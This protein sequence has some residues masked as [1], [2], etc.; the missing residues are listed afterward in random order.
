MILSS[1]RPTTMSSSILASS[2]TQPT[3][4]STKSTPT[5]H[6]RNKTAENWDDD[7]DFIPR[8]AKGSSAGL[9]TSTGPDENA[10][11]QATRIPGRSS[12]T[13]SIISSWDDSPP[14]SAPMIPTRSASKASSA[15]LHL[16]LPRH[17]PSHISALPSPSNSSSSNRHLASPIPA[18]HDQQPL[19]R[20]ESNNPSTATGQKLVKRHPSTSFITTSHPSS[21]TS[22]AS[23]ANRSSPHLPRMASRE[24]MPPPPLPPAGLQRRKS[25][26][27]S[28]LAGR[29]DEVRVSNIPFS[30]S[31]E[32][33][34]E[35]ERRPS[36]WKR[37]SGATTPTSKRESGSPGVWVNTDIQVT[38]EQRHRRRRS[39]S[40]GHES[41]PSKPRAHRPPVPPLPLG[42]R[43]SSA[44]SG[45]SDVSVIS[46]VSASSN[47]SYRSGPASAL[48]SILR[49]SSSTLSK[50]SDRS[51]K[52]PPSAYTPILRASPIPSSPGIPMPTRRD[53]T[54]TSPPSSHSF[55][56]GFHL[57]SPLPGSPY[58]ETEIRFPPMPTLPHSRSFPAP[59]PRGSDTE[60]EPEIEANDI[61]PKRKKKVRPVSELPG[62][63][64]TS[65]GSSRG[66]N[67]HDWKGFSDAPNPPP[68][69]DSLAV[70]SESRSSYHKASAS[71][72]VT[73]SS[74][75][76]G[77]FASTTS[78]FRRLG[79]ISK[80]HGRRLSG[81]FKF[82][83]GSSSSTGTSE[84]RRGSQTLETVAGSPSKPNRSPVRKQLPQPLPDDMFRSATRAGSVSAPNSHFKAN[85]M[86]KTEVHSGLNSSLS[87]DALAAKKEKKARR[88]SLGDF[89]IPK[90]VLAKQKGLKEDKGAIKKFDSGVKGE[91]GPHRPVILTLS[92]EK[93]YGATRGIM[94]QASGD[95][96]RGR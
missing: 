73:P 21:A 42:I 8:S 29:S 19:S 5:R 36:F 62:P 82:G 83:T 10:P 43:S 2:S 59:P 55:S 39:S 67:G 96:L 56:R 38:E 80:K 72:I 32:A 15:G 12:P 9:S 25:K 27:K 30:P 41:S 60:T 61:T 34:R 44:A 88:T 85:T 58:S 24:A 52:T 78:T 4:S 16:A 14:R 22:V 3:S 37:L 6:T 81:G 93:V 33:M 71:E 86:G 48:S 70:R 94:L 63:R 89:T 35:A 57:P 66:W 54:P 64:A 7:F 65:R 18:S 51:A 75:Q 69:Q 50:Q 87:E 20:I 11:S 53:A 91:S 79:S 1:S 23:Y 49:R 13:D 26:G 17:S 77:S 40:L 84:I 47:S 74:P 45:T 92:L 68:R 28:R 76:S 46:Q 31:Q 95:R 90:D